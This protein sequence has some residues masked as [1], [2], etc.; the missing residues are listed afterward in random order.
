MQKGKLSACF[1]RSCAENSWV[2]KIITVVVKHIRIVYYPS[3]YISCGNKFEK[4]IKNKFIG[5]LFILTAM[6][7][8]S[9]TVL[10]DL[11]GH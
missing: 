9:Y 2:Q 1:H 10:A 8:V 11:R 5:S 4:W 6:L 3:I 7:G